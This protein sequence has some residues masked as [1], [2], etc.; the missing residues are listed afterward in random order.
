MKYRQPQK[1]DNVNDRSRLPKQ[2]NGRI[3]AVL[4]EDYEPNEIIVLFPSHA[5]GDYVNYDAE[6]FKGTWTDKMGGVYI[7]KMK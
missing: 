5:R 2:A 4:W 6:D 3:H 7:L 1:G